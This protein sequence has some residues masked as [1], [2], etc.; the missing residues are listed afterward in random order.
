MLRS[1]NIYGPYERK[2]VFAGN[3]QH[4]GGFVDLD[5]MLG[6]LQKSDLI[7]IAARP[8]VRLAR[9]QQ[10]HADER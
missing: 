8:G 9:E 4:Q 3:G 2:S 5:K 10:Q 6:G 7:I 1:K